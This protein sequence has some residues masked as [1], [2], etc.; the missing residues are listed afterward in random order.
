MIRENNLHWFKDKK[1]LDAVN[2]LI[3]VSKK[4]DK[5]AWEDIEMPDNIGKTAWHIWMISKILIDPHMGGLPKVWTMKDRDVMIF[6]GILLNN[7]WFNGG[8]HDL[9]TKEHFIKQLK[10][11][12]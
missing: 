12:R 6:C 7:L 11:Q 2:E 10:E 5:L 8:L 3:E 4:H 1:Y 9:Y